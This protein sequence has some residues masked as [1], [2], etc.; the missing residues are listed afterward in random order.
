[1]KKVGIIYDDNIDMT[2]FN[3]SIDVIDEFKTKLE[4]ILLFLKKPITEDNFQALF[5]IC[6]YLVDKIPLPPIPIDINFLIRARPNY[7]GEV[8][9]EQWQISYN[10]R[11]TNRIKLNRFNRPM[12]SMFYGALPSE[13][14]SKMVAAATL[15]CCKEIINENNENTAQYFTF[16]KWYIKTSFLVLNLCFNDKTLESNPTLK[17]FV[18]QYL[19]HLDSKISK[20]AYE[21]IKYYWRFFSDLASKKHETDQ[22]YFIT[23]AYFCAVRVYYEQ[24]L[25]EKINGIVYPSSMTENEALN[26]VLTPNAVDSYLELKETFM[27][28]Y[29]RNP[30]TVKSFFCGIA[31]K[32][33]EVKDEKFAI[34]GIL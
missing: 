10:S 7:N 24:N 25:N 27:Y 8:F 22:Q 31:S 21:F 13:R 19:N 12:E 9:R 33:A 14:Q 1:M 26:I 17:K 2:Q 5:D 20:E 4:E 3:W 11:D 15:E 18:E 23:T 29:T 34:L 28:K 6:Y 30:S 32:I 16:G